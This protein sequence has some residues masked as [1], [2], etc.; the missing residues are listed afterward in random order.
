MRFVSVVDG[1]HYTP[2]RVFIRIDQRRKREILSS[3]QKPNDPSLNNFPS[4]EN[5]FRLFERLPIRFLH[6]Q[7]K[8]VY[9]L[10]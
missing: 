3:F 9:S 5:S 8:I 2:G 1:N 4:V 10:F 6:H 7:G